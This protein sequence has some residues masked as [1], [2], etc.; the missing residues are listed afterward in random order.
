MSTTS[1]TLKFGQFRL[2]N[3]TSRLV[4]PTNKFIKFFITSTD[5]IHSFSIPALFIKV[6][7]CPGKLNEFNTVINRAGVLYGQ[8]SEICGTNHSFMP[9]VVQAIPGYKFF[10]NYNFL[11]LLD[12]NKHYNTK[13]SFRNFYS[14]RFKELAFKSEFVLTRSKFP[15]GYYKFINA[16]KASWANLA[17]HSPEL[18]LSERTTPK[19]K[20]PLG[21]LFSKYFKHIFVAEN[22][23]DTKN[24]SITRKMRFP[25]RLKRVSKTKK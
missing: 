22:K 14:K 1:S 15:T 8:C 16:K 24:K 18:L 20:K 12:D 21:D 13:K 7:A 10:E 4:L 23:F 19:T 5:V 3:C 25:R 17:K 6:D 2:L 9:I 11:Y